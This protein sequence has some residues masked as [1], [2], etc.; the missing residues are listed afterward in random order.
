VFPT[1]S[2]KKEQSNERAFEKMTPGFALARPAEVGRAGCHFSYL[3]EFDCDVS[4][5]CLSKSFLLLFGIKK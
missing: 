3:S 5:I 1:I 2:S 4:R